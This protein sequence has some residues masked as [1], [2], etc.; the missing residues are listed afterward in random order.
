MLIGSI[1]DYT[2][3]TRGDRD[4]DSKLDSVEFDTLSEG[5][6]EGAVAGPGPSTMASRQ[7]QPTDFLSRT[8]SNPSIVGLDEK[9]PHHTNNITL[10]RRDREVDGLASELEE[11]M[12]RDDI[13]E[14][15]DELTDPHAVVK[16]LEQVRAGS[17]VAPSDLSEE[18]EWIEVDRILDGEDLPAP[19]RP[20][21]PEDASDHSRLHM[22]L[23]NMARRIRKRRGSQPMY[24]EDGGHDPPRLDTSIQT[25]S[26]TPPRSPG[27][28]VAGT[29]SPLKRPSPF[30]AIVQAKSA[31]ARRLRLRTPPSD[32][33]DVA[34]EVDDTAA[35]DLEQAPK[36]APA[37]SQATGKEPVKQVQRET[38]LPKDKLPAVPFPYDSL[39]GN[40]HRFM[41]Y[42][43]AAY[44]V[45]LSSMSHAN[46]QQHFLR[47]LR[48]G[49]G[50]YNFTSTGGHHFNSWA[51]AR[52]TNIA[53]DSLLHYS[54]TDSGKSSTADKALPLVHYVSVDHDLKSII[55]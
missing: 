20:I 27:P 35:Q 32:K 17:M 34:N 25:P 50:E 28:V 15:T 46:M 52:H 4:K 51:F 26:F 10:A 18:E 6:A 54:H 21:S 19:I 44:G 5:T 7:A 39:I 45:S 3:R 30:R 36:P 22:V 55:L 11:L 33:A 47:I 48:L 53:I 38:G 41:R 37:E 42:S 23:Q 29:T 43:S 40:L 31:F 24:Y 1:H 13:T 12:G 16:L 49:T 2:V 14:V 9:L 8:R